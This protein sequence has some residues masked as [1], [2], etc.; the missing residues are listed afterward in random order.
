MRSTLIVF[1]LLWLLLFS[2]LLYSGEAESAD[3]M[4]LREAT[5][6]YRSFLPGGTDPLITQNPYLPNRAMDKE[7]NLDVNLDL[8]NYLYWNNTVHSM[9]DSQY[10]PA[11]GGQF[12]MVGLEMG[13]GVDMR[14]IYSEL[15]ISIGYHHFSR[16]LLDTA[17]PYHF[18]C[19]DAI[20]LKIYL[21]ARGVH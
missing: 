17:S 9:T 19:Q 5:V 2:C 7:L 15:P 8:V 10:A 6:T 1:S 12:R 21:Y 16:H 11:S 20:E 13:F 3:W 14:R 18:P 4:Q